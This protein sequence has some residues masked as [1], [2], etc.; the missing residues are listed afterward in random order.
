MTWSFEVNAKEFTAATK[1]V[2]PFASTDETLPALCGVHVRFD[3]EEVTL[4][5]TDRYTLA[6]RHIK[7]EAETKQGNGEII[8]PNSTVTAITR[9][10]LPRLDSTFTVT[11]DDDDKYAIRYP[12]FSTVN[13]PAGLEGGAFPTSAHK[14]LDNFK[15]ASEDSA[16]GQLGFNV[17][18]LARFAKAAAKNEMVKLTVGEEATKPVKFEFGETSGLICT[19]RIA[20]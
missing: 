12:D 7:A 6:I 9:T 15:A 17:T 8:L 14:M 11:V 16:P 20:S 5:A 19:M 18:F 1:S 2:A 10:K 13:Y 3:G 4:T